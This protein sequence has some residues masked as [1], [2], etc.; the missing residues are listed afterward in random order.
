MLKLLCIDEVSKLTQRFYHVVGPAAFV[1]A[2]CVS[3]SSLPPIYFFE[4][5]VFVAIPM[6]WVTYCTELIVYLFELRF[7]LF[8]RRACINVKASAAR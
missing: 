5:S 3:V 8:A 1:G 4:R 7:L 2:D 6:L